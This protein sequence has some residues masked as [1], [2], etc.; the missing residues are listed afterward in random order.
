[1]VFNSVLWAFSRAEQLMDLFESL[2][3]GSWVLLGLERVFGLTKVGVGLREELFV[4]AQRLF[5]ETFLSEVRR[6]LR[7]GVYVIH[8]LLFHV[9]LVGKGVAA[10]ERVAP[11]RAELRSEQWRVGRQGFQA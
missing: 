10:V 5:G 2:E 3:S 11:G 8:L 7:D 9:F 4:E 1:M 6:L